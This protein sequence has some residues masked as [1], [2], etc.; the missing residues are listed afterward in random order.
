VRPIAIADTGPLVALLTRADAWH[1]WTKRQFEAIAAP[2]FTCESVITEAAFLL[3]RTAGGARSLLGL[4][5]RGVIE[6]RFSLQ[7]EL[8][9]IERLMRRYASVP[10]SLAD[11]CLVRMSELYSAS[12]VLT[13]DSDFSIYRRNGRQVI[14]LSAPR[15]N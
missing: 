13:L 9:S 14:P 11:A 10:M 3:S 4:L 6:V 5:D 15:I 8:E 1:S 12:T 2:L 7:A